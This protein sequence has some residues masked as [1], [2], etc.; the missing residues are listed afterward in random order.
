MTPFA[1]VGVNVAMEDALELGRAII[2]AKNLAQITPHE[3]HVELLSKAVQTYEES[4][5][6]RAKRY[7]EE[8]WMYY[9]LF[10]HERGGQPMVEQFA[11]AKAEEKAAAEAKVAAEKEAALAVEAPGTPPPAYRLS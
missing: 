3:T 2:G 10:F 1:G 4:M 11:K 8:T 6:K 5:F 7:A 9:N